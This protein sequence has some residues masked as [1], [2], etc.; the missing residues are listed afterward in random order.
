MKQN[1]A[2]AR[3]ALRIEAE[4]DR[5]AFRD[6]M[7]R[8]LYPAN[9]DFLWRHH[10]TFQPDRE[11]GNTHYRLNRDMCNMASMA[12]I[13]VLCDNRAVCRQGI[14]F[15]FKDGPGNGRIERAA[16]AG[17][18][19]VRA[20]LPSWPKSAHAVRPCH[21]A[22]PRTFAVRAAAEDG[23]GRE[24]SPWAKPALA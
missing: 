10:D 18:A 11:G 20:A 23:P 9:F 19:A 14:N 8:V 15:F 24:V 6:M 1:T 4:A 2:A 21:S 5:D 12:A 7:M 13:G 3:L 17:T 16:S 22:R